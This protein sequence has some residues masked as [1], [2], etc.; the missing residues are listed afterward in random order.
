MPEWTDEQRQAIE[1]RGCNLLVS[2]AAGSGKTAV[3]V[4]RIIQL[5]VKDQ[6]D[7][8][9]LLVVTFTKAAAAEMKERIAEALAN[10]LDHNVSQQASLR[11]QLS[12]LNYASISTLHSFCTEVIRNYF[13]MVDIDPDFR[14]GDENETG[15]LR[16]ES[17]E[18]LMEQE[19][20]QGNELF[21]D[22]V[23]MFGSSKNDL[24]LRDLIIQIYDF[25]HSQPEPDKWLQKAAAQFDLKEDNLPGSPWVMAI[26]EQVVRE[27]NGARDLFQEACK[28]A[29][30]PGGPDVYLEALEE[31]TRLAQQ[32]LELL[33]QDFTGFRTALQRVK[34]PRLKRISGDVDSFLVDMAKSL[35]EE[36]KKTISGLATMLNHTPEEL[37]QEAQQLYPRIEYLLNLVRSFR[38]IY[39][40]HKIEKGL[41][42]FSD[43]E[44]YALAIL[45]QETAAQDYQKKFEYVFVDEYQDSNGVQEAILNAVCRGDNLFMVGDVKQSIYRFR[46]ADPSMFMKKYQRFS[47]D[48]GV[49][50]RIDLGRN[51]RC[52]QEIVNAVNCLF[53]HIMSR[54]LGEI[55]YDENAF[56]YCG[57]PAY[58]SP[59][60][61]VELYLV[62]TGTEPETDAENEEDDAPGVIELEARQVARRIQ[63]LLN[64]RIYDQRIKQ[65]RRLEYRDIVV[66]LRTTRNWAGEFAEVLGNHGI[67]V[68]AD[69]SSGYFDTLEV[70]LFMNLLRVIDNKR[71]DIPLLSVMRSPIFQFG[72]SELVKIRAACKQGSYFEAIDHYITNHS[73]QLSE[74]LIAMLEQLAAWKDAARYMRMD[75]FIWKLLT[76]TGFY[77]YVSAMPGGV[78]R[79][80]NLRVLY[81][82]A[83]QF[84]E[85]SN[86]GLFSFINFIDRLQSSRR[87]MEIARALGENENVVRIMSIHKSK[88]LE[89]PVVMIAGLGKQFN[90]SDSKAPVVLHRELGLGPRL[91]DLEMR[92]Y[93]DTL[94]RLAIKNQI[95]LENLAEEMRIL[96]V[97]C[98]RAKEKLIMIGGVKDLE[99]AVNKWSRAMNFYHLSRAKCFL[100]WVVPVVM[101]HPAGKV[102]RD[103]NGVWYENTIDDECQWKVEIINRTALAAQQVESS[104][105]ETCIREWLSGLK[106]LP[107]SEMDNVINTRLDWTYPH[108]QAIKI[109][110]KLSVTQLKRLEVTELRSLGYNIP[111]LASPQLDD[112]DSCKL[113]A[114]KRGTVVHTVMQHLDF[115]RVGSLEQIKEQLNDLVDKEFITSLESQA[116]KP[117]DILAFFRSPLGQRVL[118]ASKIHRET[119]F[120]LA[121]TAGQVL[122]GIASNEDMLIQGVIDLYFEEP[123]GLVLIDF[124]TDQVLADNIRIL[125]EEY[126]VQLDWYQKALEAIQGRK[127][128][129]R[130]LYSFNLNQAIKA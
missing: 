112:K 75:D 89:F 95:K 67:P 119:P 54:E 70:S 26:K 11:R 121:C 58:D 50:R 25:I 102:L 96:Y 87:D 60:P 20:Q 85:T 35:R 84:E 2:A 79:Q 37:C 41:L 43:L 118:A 24:P 3:L 63:S 82:R 64:T 29:Q 108:A 48:G 94:A 10:E 17:L 124:K 126:Q 34:H 49:E 125:V 42:D 32:L 1:A 5:L 91:V 52:R 69:V 66:L 80:A 83:R 76:E 68:Y 46:L 27:L 6:V 73:N 106:P 56:L 97:A 86:R 128:K 13:Y 129:E 31:D 57:I 36:G 115:S 12:L 61:D 47:V 110:S 74:N 33:K 103:L 4:E 21:F 15:L 81:D 65:Y 93:T 123:D 8:D 114:W 77:S 78:Q 28:L 127:V 99:K 18:E 98:T 100:D 9:R 19:Y 116:V 45:K 38:D 14:V 120:N 51:F 40:E 23:E 105:Q 16:T 62:E 90:T 104:T 111:S 39:N 53:Q 92:A 55:D 59:N 7:I 88:G 130:Y 122:P 71:Q 109:P 101:R 107:V 117:V 22:L 30:L 113:P 44:H 72:V